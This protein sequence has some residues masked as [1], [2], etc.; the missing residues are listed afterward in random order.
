[1]G[2]EGGKPVAT[3]GIADSEA[4]VHERE[5]SK[6]LQGTEATQYRALAARLNY[7]ALDRADL[8]FAAKEISKYMSSPKDADWVK[9]KR[10]GRYLLGTPRYVQSFIWQDMPRELTTF[11]DSDWAGDKVS[12][13]STSGGALMCGYHLLKSWSSTQPVIALSSGEA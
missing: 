12:R 1:M 11:A 2:L 13:K 7:L 5:E 4:D 10:V 6:D 9:I 3:P 8:Q